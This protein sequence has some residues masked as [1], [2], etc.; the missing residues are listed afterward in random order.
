MM[1]FCKEGKV[2]MTGRFLSSVFMLII[3]I[4]ATFVVFICVTVTQA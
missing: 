4:Q 1:R 2:L 3:L